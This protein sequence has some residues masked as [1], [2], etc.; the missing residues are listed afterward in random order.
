M[1]FEIFVK[2]Y[3]LKI[4]CPWMP[5]CVPKRDVR[6]IAF[7]ANEIG[8]RKLLNKKFITEKSSPLFSTFSASQSKFEPWREYIIN[9]IYR[10]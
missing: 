3:F 1:N 10:Y 8:W 4:K 6:T 9:E 7:V 5:K 2:V